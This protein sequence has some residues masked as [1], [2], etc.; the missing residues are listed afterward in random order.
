MWTTLIVQPLTNILIVFYNVLGHDLGIAI[1]AL[2]VLIRLVLYPL[3]RKAIAGQVAMQRIQPKMKELQQQHKGNREALAK[4]TMALYAEQ[5]VNPLSSCLP[6]LV[7]LPFLLGIYGALRLAFEGGA[8]S[9]LYAFVAH[10]TELR[11]VAFGF[12]PMGTSSIP[13]ALLAGAAQFWVMKMLVDSRPPTS[14]AQ[15]SG[16]D[17]DMMTMMNKQ[18]KYM[19]PIVTVVIGATLPAGLTLYWLVTTLFQGAQQK[20]AFASIRGAP[21]PASE[22][23]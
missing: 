12:L 6:T 3:S 7:Q 21:A 13:L 20:L 8:Q 16:K 19:M 11:D 9:L 4:A 23:K 15:S 14:V 1:I 2:T 17:E 10:P 5:K 22:K 18:M